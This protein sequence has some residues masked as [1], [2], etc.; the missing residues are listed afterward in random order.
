MTRVQTKYQG[1]KLLFIQDNGA[2]A[3]HAAEFTLSG[4]EYYFLGGVYYDL[5][6]KLVSHIF[7]DV[8]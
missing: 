4:R 3:L 7:H 2:K 5:D 6:D 8:K 1:S